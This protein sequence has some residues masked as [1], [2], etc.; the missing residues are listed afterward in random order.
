MNVRD[1]WNVAAALAKFGDDVLQV[2]RVLYRRCGDADDLATDGDE[3][4]RLLH[5]GLGVHRV[6]GD[7]G[8]HG[9]GMLATDNDTPVGGITDDGLARAAA[10]VE[11]GRLAVAHGNHLAGAGGGSDLGAN[12]ISNFLSRFHGKSCTS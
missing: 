11:V 3:V 1:D 12:L 9:D 4:Q 5:A 8:L 6:A 7:H 2:G 10:F